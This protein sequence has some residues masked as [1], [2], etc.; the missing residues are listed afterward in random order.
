MGD[1]ILADPALARLW[2][3]DGKREKLPQLVQMDGVFE[4]VAL[5]I[6][7]R[8][9]PVEQASPIP[10]LIR[11]FLRDLGSH[12]RALLIKQLQGVFVAYERDDLARTLSDHD[13]PPTPQ[14]HN[15]DRSNGHPL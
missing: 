5:L 14:P 2:W 9:E 3:L 12:H 8:S 7:Q 4:Q 6:A 13:Q 15:N 11:T 1:Q 10:E